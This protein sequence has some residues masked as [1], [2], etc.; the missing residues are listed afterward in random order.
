MHRFPMI[1]FRRKGAL[2]VLSSEITGLHD[3]SFRS[4]V[5]FV[6]TNRGYAMRPLKFSQNTAMAISEDERQFFIELGAR[7][8]DLRKAQNIT[9][10]QMAEALG[11]SQQ[12]INSYE[13]GRRRIPVS[14]LPT[15][16][17]T[18]AVSIEELL[19]EPAPKKTNGKRGPA[20]KLQQQI[21]IISQ[22]PSAKQKLAYDML[23][24]IIQQASSDQ[25]KSAG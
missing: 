23:N 18:L 25:R 6:M 4:I 13:V 7:V 17:R 20:S 12:T 19:G 21:D 9:Q 24:A 16:A 22:L 1:G 3:T 5:N 11:V 8:A 14:A 10:V 15:L 2:F